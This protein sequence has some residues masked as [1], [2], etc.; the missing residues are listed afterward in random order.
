MVSRRATY[1]IKMV[2]WYRSSPMI[3]RAVTQ[4]VSG[5]A[6]GL[7]D[8]DFDVGPIS[9]RKSTDPSSKLTIE[10]SIGH[11]FHEEVTEP[12]TNTRVEQKGHDAQQ[13]NSR[14]L[15]HQRNSRRRD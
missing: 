13:H 14:R 9:A 10:F 5:I 4:T 15:H 12:L 3:A 11:L 6:T 2:E 7:N 1:G 8:F